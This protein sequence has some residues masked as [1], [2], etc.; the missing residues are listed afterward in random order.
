MS[1][2]PGQDLPVAAEE[3]DD[4]GVLAG[5]RAHRVVI[6]EPVWPRGG[7][8]GRD[9]CP[10]LSL[11]WTI[12]RSGVRLAD[13]GRSRSRG[14]RLLA[15]RDGLPGG[16]TGLFRRLGRDPRRVGLDGKALEARGKLRGSRPMAL[17]TRH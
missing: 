7:T 15:P 12:R 3:P 13:D 17:G 2:D 11:T 9:L 5:P 16:D 4:G 1:H 6:L 8:G 10:G 14:G